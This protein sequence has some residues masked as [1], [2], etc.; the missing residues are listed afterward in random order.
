MDETAMVLYLLLL[1][2]IAAAWIAKSLFTLRS[3]AIFKWLPLGYVYLFCG[4]NTA[5]FLGL[6]REAWY[7]FFSLALL[8]VVTTWLVLHV[9][10][11]AS[12]EGSSSKGKKLSET[13]RSLRQKKPGLERE[14]KRVKAGLEGELLVAGELEKLPGSY[15]LLNDV[16]LSPE[17]RTRQ[18]DHVVVGPAGVLAL[19]TK[20]ISGVVQPF[21][22]GILVKREGIAS[23]GTEVKTEGDPRRQARFNA[24][25]LSGLLAL[26]VKPV[27]VL[28]HPQGAWQGTVEEDCP[29]LHLSDLL[30]Y[31]LVELPRTMKDEASIA[32]VA[33]TVHS[34]ALS[35]EEKALT[36]AENKNVG[37]CFPGNN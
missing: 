2:F 7:S 23:P 22:E 6:L 13:L 37:Y 25:K 32:S 16:P 14:L 17:E 20:H 4:Y 3:P 30:R 1:I 36:R 26:P 11:R 10:T 24:R 28:S 5:A 29:V 18:V 34:L 21:D 15:Y 33:G 19:E 27:V 35:A 31:I 12:A 8:N 9:N